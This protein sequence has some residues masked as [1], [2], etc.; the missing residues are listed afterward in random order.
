VTYYPKRM[1]VEELEKTYDWFCH[2]AYSP[3]SI[4]RRGLRTLRRYPLPRMPRK[5]FGSFSTDYGYRHT[6]G[7]RHVDGNRLLNAWGITG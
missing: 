1:T 4:A 6:F 5:F 2:Q 7:W 3:L